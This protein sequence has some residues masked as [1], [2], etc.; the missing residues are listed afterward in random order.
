MGLLLEM[1]DGEI[2]IYFPALN[3]STMPQALVIYGV[4]SKLL[5]AEGHNQNRNQM[6]ISDDNVGSI[7]VSNKASTYFSLSSS[8]EAK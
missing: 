7:D 6:H 1:V 2:D 4:I 3:K 5:S 8:Y